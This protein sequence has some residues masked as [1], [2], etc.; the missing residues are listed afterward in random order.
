VIYVLYLSRIKKQQ[1]WK[2]LE[3]EKSYENFLHKI[4]EQ[5]CTVVQVLQLRENMT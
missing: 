2:K 1:L 4:L 3:D 5:G